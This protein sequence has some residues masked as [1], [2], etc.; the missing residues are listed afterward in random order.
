MDNSQ[1]K[2]II[3]EGEGLKTEFKLATNSVPNDM[4]ETVVS[5]SNTDG[6]IIILGVDDNGVIQGIDASK[7]NNMLKD[8]VSALNSV[9][10]IKPALFLQPSIIEIENKLII[11]LQV[12]VSSLIHNHKGNIYIRQYES[13]ID[14]TENHKKITELYLRKSSVFTE[15]QVIDSLTMDDFDSKLFDKA[16]QLIRSY[17]SDHPWLT[18]SNLNML[19]EAAL[20]KKDYFSL[21]EGYTLAC[22][23]IFGKDSTIQSILSAYKV[24]VM[25]RRENV[26]RWDDRL[27][28][29]T[30]LIDTYINIK[31]FINRHLPE[32]FYME[33][34]QRIDLRDKVFR[35]VIGNTVVH[36]EYSSAMATEI[37]ID[38]FQL[39]AKNP[40]KPH[41]TG[42]I[43]L[44]SFSPYAKNP[45]IRR[46]FTAM[47]W[48]DEIGSGIRNTKK[49]LPLYVNGAQPSFIEGSEFTTIIPLN[50]VNLERFAM[51]WLE[52]LDLSV[53]YHNHLKESLANVII[54]SE[55]MDASFEECILNL[56]PSYN[57]KGTKLDVLDWPKKQALTEDEI[58]LVPSYAEKGT[59]LLHK[60]VRY[61]LAILSLTA[62]PL[63]L[64]DIMSAIGYSNKATFRRNYISPL[65]KL[66]FITKTNL[67]NLTAPDQK[68]KL[69]AKGALFL[70]NK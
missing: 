25:V 33:G 11:V 64:D 37:I 24:E 44:E 38:K 30:N 23:L 14:I 6:G 42:P 3:I 13:D 45:N 1:I 62:K 20:W 2:K 39:I 50:L 68:Y 69:T 67:S 59:K 12:P 60:K 32:K 61:I 34:D 5:F 43:D 22:V 8:L 35:E 18:I 4:Y 51:R 52:W 10:N 53:D 57:R 63:S 65:E 47:G 17:Q 19:K 56:V 41:F 55:L 58:K 46:F 66:E 29:R 9:D 28:L 40:N 26:D 36:R 16:R 15:N 54:S 7:K 49:Y 27:T 21:Q 70:G 48:T 31:S